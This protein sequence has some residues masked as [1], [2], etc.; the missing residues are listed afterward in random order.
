LGGLQHGDRL[1]SRDGIGRQRCD[2][3]L[4][5]QGVGQRSRYLRR[6]NRPKPDRSVPNGFWA[7][8]AHGDQANQ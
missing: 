7:G 6:L 3:W 5:G 8:C 2:R 4:A 1:G